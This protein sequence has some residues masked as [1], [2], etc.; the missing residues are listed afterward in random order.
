MVG[1]G[2]GELKKMSLPPFV[3]KIQIKKKQTI[4]QIKNTA[5]KE[6]KRAVFL[7]EIGFS[8]SKAFN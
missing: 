7:K 5:N 3:K 6:K 4:K 8:P 1:K 2:R